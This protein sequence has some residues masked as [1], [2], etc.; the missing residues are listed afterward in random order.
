MFLNGHRLS[1]QPFIH[2]NYS[3]TFLWQVSCSG[4][5]YKNDGTLCPSRNC[6]NCSDTSYDQ[7]NQ[8]NNLTG[9]SPKRGLSERGGQ[10]SF[11]TLDSA[12]L[13]YCTDTTH[14][15]K[16]KSYVACCGHPDCEPPKSCKDECSDQCNRRTEVYNDF[17]RQQFFSGE[18]VTL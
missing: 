18:H 9:V 5:C 2:I 11:W 13:A 17:C 14:D 1:V 16:V 6:S 4:F 7:T 10:S 8:S 3:C 15:C 12:S